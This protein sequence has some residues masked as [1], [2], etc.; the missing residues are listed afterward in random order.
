MVHIL[1]G[2]LGGD[3][4]PTLF[5]EG[6]AVYLSGGHYKPELLM[7]R[8]AA[9]LDNQLGWY[10]PLQALAD[11]F[12]AS[13]HEIGYLE[14]GA[15]VEYML[16]AYGWEAF[17]AF[18]RDIHPVAGGKQSDAIDAALQRHFNITFSQL[19]ENYVNALKTTSTTPE[20]V[21]DVHITVTLFNT[22]RRYQQVLDPSAYFRTAWLLDSKQLRQNGI[23]ADFTRHPESA[24][25]LALEV[26]FISAGEDLD[27]PPYPQ[28]NRLLKAVNTVLDALEQGHP[29]PFSADSLANDYYS[30][31]KVLLDSGQNPQTIYVD[32]H[33]AIVEVGSGGDALENL[34]FYKI[35][36]EWQQ[37]K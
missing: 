16:Q 8:A 37:L 2:R 36:G 15:L 25:N 14:A 27:L 21:A 7:P 11:D 33:S 34:S 31:V 10:L 20:W 22:M 6:L 9:L 32:G 4:R 23:S 30:I 12:Y 28:A 24:E 26:M 29:E 1:D 35:D 13:Q 18:Y 5:V 17:S 19:E 3:L